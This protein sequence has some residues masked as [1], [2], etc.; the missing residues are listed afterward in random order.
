MLGA[1]L[2][3]NLLGLVVVAV[4]L[5]LASI[6]SERWLRPVIGQGT[7]R[8]GVASSIFIGVPLAL[9]LDASG[10]RTLHPQ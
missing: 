8:F 3:P 6:A 9:A 4:A 5:I 10:V 2:R 1:P 7:L